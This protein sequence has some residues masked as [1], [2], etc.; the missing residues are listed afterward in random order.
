MVV[1][2]AW[3]SAVSRSVAT[4]ARNSSTFCRAFESAYNA[5][6]N[7]AKPTHAY[8]KHRTVV[9]EYCDGGVGRNCRL[10]S[11]VGLY[12]PR[13]V[14]HD[15]VRRH[16]LDAA[17]LVPA[18]HYLKGQHLTNIYVARDML[19]LVGG[20]CLVRCTKVTMGQQHSISTVKP[21]E[22]IEAPHL[23]RI[24]KSIVFPQP[25]RII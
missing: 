7:T 22:Q 2:L 6:H 15:N 17:K 3:S 25:T 18:E 13:N 8:V 10:L 11:F 19:A 4:S 14:S 5:T 20:E 23:H 1:D 9:F 16:G 21:S 24:A 12:D